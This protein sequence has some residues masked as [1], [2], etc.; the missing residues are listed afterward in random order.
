MCQKLCR[1]SLR[2]CLLTESARTDILVFE[3]GNDIF[4]S[5]TSTKELAAAKVQTFTKT[6]QVSR[7]TDFLSLCFLYISCETRADKPTLEMS[8]KLPL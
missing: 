2:F 8:I 3:F 4:F 1:N 5:V 7:L 6:R